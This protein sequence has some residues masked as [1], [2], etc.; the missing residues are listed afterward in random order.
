MGTF[1][2]LVLFSEFPPP[3]FE[4]LYICYIYRFFQEYFQ[5]DTT[6]AILGGGFKMNMKNFYFFLDDLFSKISIL[7]TYQD[8]E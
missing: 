3:L 2:L 7:L 8:Y 4:F 1:L 6:H 5:K